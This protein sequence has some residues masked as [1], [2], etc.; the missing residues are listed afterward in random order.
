MK[1]IRLIDFTTNHFSVLIVS[2]SFLIESLGGFII[3]LSTS[4][5]G[6]TY[7]PLWNAFISS[8][9]LIALAKT[10]NT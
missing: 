9:C 2:N 8:C 6:F 4:N 7:F 10:F 5:D 3:I 1:N